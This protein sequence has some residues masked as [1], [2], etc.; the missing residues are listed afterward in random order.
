MSDASTVPDEPAA[1]AAV[2]AISP[3]AEAA[4]MTAV[5]RRAV[6]GMV[7]RYF[8]SVVLFVVRDPLFTASSAR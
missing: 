1:K 4:A 8:M 7:G 2:A 3:A 5:I 6:F